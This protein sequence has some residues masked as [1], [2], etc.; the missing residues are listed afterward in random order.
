MLASQLS[1]DLAPAFW[2]GYGR[3]TATSERLE[4]SL[5]LELGISCQLSLFSCYLLTG[6]IFAQWLLGGTELGFL[7]YLPVHLG[8]G[9]S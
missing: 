9:W 2:A 4:K 5:L 1:R 7:R 3:R 6:S 8:D